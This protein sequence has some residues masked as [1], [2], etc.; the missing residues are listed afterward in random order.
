CWRGQFASQNQIN[1]GAKGDASHELGNIVTAHSHSVRLHA[2]DRSV[3]RCFPVG[4]THE[5]LSFR[6]PENIDDRFRQ[7]AKRIN[8]GGASFAQSFHLTGVRTATALDDRSRMTIS[9]AVF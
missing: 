8:Y 2:R 6:L 4:F 5:T 7:F 3:P 9:Y 1:R